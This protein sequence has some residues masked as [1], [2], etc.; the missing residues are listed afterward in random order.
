MPLKILLYSPSAR[1]GVAEHTFYQARALEMAG[2]EVCVLTPPSFL[3][4][5]ECPFP[6][7]R[8]LP[9]PI[10]GDSGLGKKLRMVW[11]IVSSRYILAWKILCHRPDLILLDSYVEYMAPLW[12]DPHIILARIF[13]FRYAANLH[14]PVR[15]Y[16]I[17]PIWWHRLSVWLAYQPLDFVFVHHALADPS[18]VP[19]RVKVMVAPHG[20]YD[21]I[22][23][24][25]D[26]NVIRGEWGVMPRQRVFLSYGFIRDG[27]NLDLVIRAL[28]QVP[29]ALLIV[30]GS[31]ASS[32]DKPVEFYR[33]LAK[34]LGVSDRCLFFEGYLHDRETGRY[35]LGTD[36]ILLTYSSAFHSQSGV[37]NQAAKTR[38]PVL[39]SASP[40]PMI[41]FVKRYSLGVAVKPDSVEAITDGM[42]KLMETDINPRWDEYESVASWD[43][44]AQR[45]IQAAEFKSR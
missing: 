40:S 18:P 45:V 32:R 21:V 5:R 26:R 4:G 36:F 3:K 28:A 2:A 7:D 39:A 24:G 33:T 16:A 42:K 8:C 38:R 44:N 10:S 22:L 15:S 19:K 34:E 13:G 1:G 37:L 25:H 6:V 17:G 41:E 27:K 9:D 20:L 35:F 14:D 12:I 11:E 29:D 23:A 30:A 31:V 43:V